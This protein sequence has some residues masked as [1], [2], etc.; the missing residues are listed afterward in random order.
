MASKRRATPGAGQGT[1][2]IVGGRRRR[3]RVELAV[4]GAIREGQKAG[5]LDTKLDAGAAAL[6]R[7]LAAMVDVAARKE[8]VWAAAQAGRQLSEQLTRLGLDPRARAGGVADELI[9]ELRALGKAETDLQPR[10]GEE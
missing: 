10:G 6:A 1:L 9:E 8:D 5:S 4:D 7:E 3:Y 2:A